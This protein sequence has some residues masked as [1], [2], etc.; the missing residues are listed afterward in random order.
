MFAHGVRWV[1]ISLA[2]VNVATGALIACILVSVM[3]TPVVDR[4]HPAVRYA[5][6]F[7]RRLDDSGLLSFQAASAI[8]EL[9][10]MGRVRQ[11]LC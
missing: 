2:G 11:Q 1:L 5:R 8:V 6:L 7:H 9:V 4:L 10:S 3:V